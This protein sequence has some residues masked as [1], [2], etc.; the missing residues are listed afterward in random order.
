MTADAAGPRVTQNGLFVPSGPDPEKLEVTI[1]RLAKLVGEGNL[2]CAEL[3]DS[4]RPESFRMKRF[5]VANE[6]NKRRGKSEPKVKKLDPPATVTALR[7][8]RPPQPVRLEL[9]D[10]QPLRMYLQGMSAEVVSASG[11]WRSSGDWWQE[12]PWRQDEWDLEIEFV[13]VGAQ[14]HC[15]PS[16]QN[17]NFIDSPQSQSAS[18]TKREQK[19]KKTEHS[20]RQRGLYR[21]YYDALRQSWFVR[22]VY[23]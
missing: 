17:V 5:V 20:G 21:I 6:Q 2:G 15:A 1:A 19:D 11:P 9:R 3:V 4:H 14:H 23:D 22:G 18:G 13:P 10:E 8:M 7:V 16:R 12:D